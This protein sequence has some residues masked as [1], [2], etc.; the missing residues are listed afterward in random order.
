MNKKDVTE[1][2]EEFNKHVLELE[3]LSFF[4]KLAGSGYTINIEAATGVTKVEY[5]GPDDEAIKAF[6]NDIRKFFQGNDT[7]FIHKLRPV[8]LSKYAEQ[9]EK[10]V[11]YKALRD[12]DEFNKKY[13]RFEIV[14]EKLT[15]ERIFEVF[16]YGKISHRTKNIKNVYDFW[17]K[18]PVMYTALKNEFIRVSSVYSTILNNIVCANEQVLKKLADSG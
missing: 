7:L 11:F 18:H 5:R 12:F 10:D 4:D 9:S 14:T 8:Y 3:S 17:K 2:L 1:K 13:T 6:G 16:M 15:N